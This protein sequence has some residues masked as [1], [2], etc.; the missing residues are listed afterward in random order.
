ML[1]DRDKELLDKAY[2]R[3]HLTARGYY[4]VLKVARTIA[5]LEGCDSI[6]KKHL[7]EAISYRNTYE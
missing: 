6:S 7:T 3:Y 5:D 4:K 2:R 1:G